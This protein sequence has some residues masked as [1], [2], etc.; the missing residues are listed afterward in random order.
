MASARKPCDMMIDEIIKIAEAKKYKVEATD[1]EIDA[2]M[3]R[4]AKGLNTDLPGLRSQTPGTG[5]CHFF[6][7]AVCGRANCLLRES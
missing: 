1:K 6:P 5:N 3:L 7:E 2:H 4:V